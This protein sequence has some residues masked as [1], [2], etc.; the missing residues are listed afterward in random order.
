M[1]GSTYF[2]LK[3]LKKNFKTSYYKNK[4]TRK[5]KDFEKLPNKEIYFTLQSNST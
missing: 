2:E 4:D 3:L 1:T 5:V